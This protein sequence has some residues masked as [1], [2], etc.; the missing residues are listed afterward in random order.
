MYNQAKTDSQ[1]EQGF[2]Y[3]GH[4]CGNGFKSKFAEHFARK[5]RFDKVFGGQ[6]ANRKAANI[7]ENDS[8]FIISLYAAGLNKSNFKISA[9]EDILTI[10]YSAPKTQ[11]ND[12]VSFSHQEYE[13]GSFERSFQLNGKVLTDSISATYIDGVLI[14]TLPKNPA[15]NIPAQEVPVS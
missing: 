2:R 4:G 7:Q 5:G 9:T 8:S 10:S 3:N 13:F 12:G 11:E 1:N 14:V 15:T 6:F